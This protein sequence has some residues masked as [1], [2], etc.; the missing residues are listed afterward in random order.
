[1]RPLLRRLTPA[2]AL[3]ALVAPASAPAEEVATNLG[4][5][6]FVGGVKIGKANLVARISEDGY[7][8]VGYAKST[9]VVG[10][11]YEVDAQ[12]QVEGRRGADNAISPL[13]FSMS[14]VTDGSENFAMTIPYAGDA[15]SGIEAQPPLR[16]VHY[17]IEPTEQV[18]T[19]D[20]LSA[21]M[22]AM[23]PSDVNQPCG[24]TLPI[25][26]GRRRFDIIVDLAR[27][28][29]QR[30]GYR[31]IVCEARYHRVGGFKEKHMNKPDIPFTVT[32]AFIGDG[33]VRPVRLQGESEFGAVVAVLKNY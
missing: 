13:E 32:F 22:A 3:L 5:K 11:F 1:M 20:P 14:S 12:V 21:L 18:G 24:R 8:L 23:L 25:F 26:D 9:G 33:F 4:Y 10:W 17:A 15:P 19:L 28:E 30:N 7:S 27:R 31:H 2:L 29:Y 6:V 16:Q